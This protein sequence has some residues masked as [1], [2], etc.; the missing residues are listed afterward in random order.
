MDPTV[1]YVDDEDANLFLFKKSFE[2]IYKVIT[3]KS[4]SEGLAQLESHKNEI[5]IVISD[6]RMPGMNGIEFI[7]KARAQYDNLA[8]FI[9][10][11]YSND[12]EIETA[13][14]TGQ[15]QRFFIKP[16]EFSK[17]TEAIDESLTDL[18]FK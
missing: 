8:Y 2:S 18:N 16:F 12:D 14:K 1:L 4:G 5:I 6:M 11:G 13:L 7:T 15:I 9:L 17:I 3:A 10:T